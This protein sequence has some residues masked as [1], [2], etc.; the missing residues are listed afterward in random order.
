[1]SVTVNA[2]RVGRSE[3]VPLAAAV[4]G[5][6]SDETIDIHMFMFVIE[7][8]GTRVVV[9]TGTLAPEYVREHHPY[10]FVRAPEELPET[11][12][13]ECGVDPDDVDYVVN[14]HLHWD[15]C[16][17]NALFR[18]AR[19]LVGR[20]ELEYA[21]HPLPLHERAYEK[22]P[23][24]QAPWMSAWDRTEAVSHEQE[25]CPGVTVVPLPGHTPGS[26]GVL[27]ETDAGRF[28]LAGDA[29]GVY[30][31]WDPHD[32]RKCVA[33]TIHTNLFECYDTFQFVADLDCE[34][35]P[36]HDHRI[37]DSPLFQGRRR[38][39]VVAAG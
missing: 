33:P 15:H 16:S 29:I 21:I 4:Y 2:I 12:L 28:L 22:L 24:L 30:E 10:A 14:T 38:D 25:I 5:S 1:M 17:N 3:N 39:D 35:I 7:A 20:R 36:S 27:V 26:Q 18:N 23:G 13:R 8:A 11:A 9:D 32:W 34:V 31:N 6:A 37:L 19:I